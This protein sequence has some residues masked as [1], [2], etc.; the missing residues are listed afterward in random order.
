MKKK[1]SVIVC[2]VL[3]LSLMTGCTTFNNFKNAFFS[4]NSA[5]TNV[6]KSERTIKDIYYIGKVKTWR[7]I[8]FD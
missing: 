4:D 2:L 8:A 5:I 7:E 3:I 1:L 6:E